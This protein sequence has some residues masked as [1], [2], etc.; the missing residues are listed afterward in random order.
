[1]CFRAGRPA[2]FDSLKEALVEFARCAIQVIEIEPHL[3]A[4]E[5]AQLERGRA[6]KICESVSHDNPMTAQDCADAIREQTHG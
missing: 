5:A 6:A 4:A 1:M 2:V 3:A